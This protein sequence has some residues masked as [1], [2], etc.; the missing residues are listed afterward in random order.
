MTRRLFR[1]IIS[2]VGALQISQSIGGGGWDLMDATIARQPSTVRFPHAFSLVMAISTFVPQ[3]ICLIFE[4]CFLNKVSTAESSE[5][6]IYID[7]SCTRVQPA[8]VWNFYF[9]ESPFSCVQGQCHVF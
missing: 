4:A 6:Q 1:A 8:T 3:L 9:G 5:V 2:L 7:G